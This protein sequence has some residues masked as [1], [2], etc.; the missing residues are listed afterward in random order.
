MA[1]DKRFDVTLCLSIKEVKEDGPVPFFDNTLN[2]HELTYD[3]VVAMESMLLDVLNQLGDAG[4]M[5]AME[6]GLGEKLAMM[7]MG[8]K[9]A[10]LQ[11]K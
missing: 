11:A 10:A 4:V 3:G 8:D 9:M 7:G 2:Y 6:L 5:K 1:Q